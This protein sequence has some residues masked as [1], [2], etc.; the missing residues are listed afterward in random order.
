MGLLV[1]IISLTPQEKAN[2]TF[3]QIK[4]N[5]PHSNPAKSLSWILNRLEN[6]HPGIK[7]TITQVSKHKRWQHHF[8][9]FN[10][11]KDTR[12]P[13]AHQ[14]PIL[15][16][17]KIRKNFSQYYKSVTNQLQEL[18]KEL[19]KQTL[20]SFFENTL[21]SVIT[22]FELAF[23]L[24]EIGMGCFRYLALMEG[25]IYYLKSEIR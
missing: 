21:T 15:T 16:L 14:I 4:K 5:S 19:K 22:D 13:I 24:R 2:E 11:L 18:N 17:E 25:L 1:D 8:K 10:T 9:T 6:Y 7:K 20:P 12:D 23:Y 3:Q